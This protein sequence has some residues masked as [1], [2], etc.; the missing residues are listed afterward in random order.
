MNRMFAGALVTASLGAMGCSGAGGAGAGVD[1]ASRSASLSVSDARSGL[2]AAD[3]AMSD[4]SAKAGSAQGFA[5]FLADDAVMLVEG[6]YALKGREAIRAWLATHPLEEGGTVHWEPVRWD[7]SA[8]GTLGYSVGT[9]TVDADGATAKAM[10][11]YIS[12][13]RRQP[14]GQWRVAVTVRNAA[15]TPMTPPAGFS[16][17]HTLPAAAPRTVPKDVVLAE[18]K[19]ADT[20]FSA[21]SV[22]E[23]MGKAFGAY[24]AE[25]AVLLGG[26]AGLFGQDTIAKAYAPFTLDQ[27]DL[28]WE[29]VLGDA[30][31]SGDLA[32]T[33][34]RAVSSGKDAQGKPEIEH[35]KYLTVWRRQADGQWRYVTDGGNSSPGPQG[36]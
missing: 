10:G 21:M 27:I 25:D 32:Y 31:A 4:A 3:Q 26:A 23:G 30:A 6:S 16:T 36:P 28:R 15:K 8:D 34:G 12:T 18:A 5:E 13:W 22:Q 33:V 24:A 17:S 2:R 29:P 14:D 19:A 20:A 7:V 1:A 11:R 9:S 35:V